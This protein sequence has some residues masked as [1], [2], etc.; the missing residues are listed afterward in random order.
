MIVVV[1]T[2]SC[3]RIAVKETEPN[4]T[5]SP[6]SVTQSVSVES[7]VK[8]AVSNPNYLRECKDLNPVDSEEQISYRNIWPGKTKASEL[9]LILGSPDEKYTFSGTTDWVYD[10]ISLSIEGDIVT[11]VL[12]SVDTGTDLTLMEIILEYGCPN[13]IFAVNTTEDQFGYTD[14]R[15]VYHNIG[16]EFS[17]RRYPASLNDTP[18]HVKYF[19]PMNLEEYLETNEW[20][21]LDTYLG[22]PIEWNDAIE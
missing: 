10:D 1:L 18:S 16:A 6:K 7:L 2:T 3:S 9:E 11:E 5:P 22:K 14:T 12:I 19:R 20:T 17:F 4:T 21:A 13:I 15:F 8:T